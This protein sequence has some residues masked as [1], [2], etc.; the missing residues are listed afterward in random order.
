[1]SKI[2]NATLND[3][4]SINDLS[5]H[6]GYESV[7][8]EI[9]V[10]RL[11]CL[12]KSTNDEVWVFEESDIILGWIHVFKAHRVASCAFNEIGGLVVEPKSRGLGIGRQ[13]VEFVAEKSK[14]KNIELRVRCN[15][16]REGTHLFYEKSGFK[17]SKVQSVFQ[18]HL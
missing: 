12:L 15:S 1:M 16:Q 13:L 14:N 3:A 4:T 2:R 6:L 5:L 7:S 9:A 8:S 18:L 17:K 10:E 11:K